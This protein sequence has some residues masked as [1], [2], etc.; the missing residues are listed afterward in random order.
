MQYY[1]RFNNSKHCG[2][3]QCLCIFDIHFRIKI[4]FNITNNAEYK[5]RGPKRQRIRTLNGRSLFYRNKLIAD[6]MSYYLSVYWLR[7]S[8]MNISNTVSFANWILLWTDTTSIQ[9]NSIFWPLY[10]PNLL[11]NPHGTLP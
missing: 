10:G 11:W 9:H 3:Q 5:S 2:R 6:N 7:I 4:I 1:S 8:V